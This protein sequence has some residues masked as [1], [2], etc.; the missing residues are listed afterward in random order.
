MRKIIFL[1]LIAAVFMMLLPAAGVAATEEF[2][3]VSP[4]LAGQTI[5]VGEVRVWNDDMNVYVKYVM[6]NPDWCLIETHLAVEKNL[7][8]IPQN[9]GGPIPGQFEFK[10]P[11]DCA[12][13]QLYTVPLSWASA[14]QVYIAAHAVVQTICGYED[15]DLALFAGMLPAEATMIATDPYLGGPA[16]FPEIAVEDDMLTGTYAGWCVSTALGLQGGVLYNANVF[17]SYDAMLPDGLVDFPENLDKINWILNQQ[18]VGKPTQCNPDLPVYTYGSVQ[19]A[20]WSL[21]DDENSDLSLGPYSRCQVA[22]ILDG[23]E[24]NGSFYE[25]GCNETI[26]VLLQPFDGQGLPAQPVIIPVPLPCDQNFCDETAWG[27]GTRFR[28]RGNWATYFTY[29]IEGQ[30]IKEEIEKLSK[31][32]LRQLKK[33]MKREMKEQ[34][35]LERMM[36]KNKNPQGVEVL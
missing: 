26:G 8:D 35:K 33:K 3:L 10:D 5:P 21:I 30:V 31:K 34:R 22:E 2:P 12:P 19:R 4:L 9:P 24:E 36:R 20:I 1:P 17:S 11:V 28:E 32:E 25:P 23:A 18:F 6:T 14:T 16:Y 7:A 13:E 29:V 15:P 27:D